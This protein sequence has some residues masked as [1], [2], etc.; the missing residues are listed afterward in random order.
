MFRTFLLHCRHNVCSYGIVLFSI[1][2]FDECSSLK[3]S[4]LVINNFYYLINCLKISRI[5]S[6]LPEFLDEVTKNPSLRSELKPLIAA[7]CV[8]FLRYEEDQLF[9][10]P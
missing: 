1:R 4:I 3:I 7:N 2:I 9:V 5:K 6:Y 10:L 8:P